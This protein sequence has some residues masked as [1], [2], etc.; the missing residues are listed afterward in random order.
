MQTLNSSR[1]TLRALL[2]AA[3]VTA[4]L[5]APSTSHAQT[6]LF[7]YEQDVAA[8]DY[9]AP[10][11]S[12]GGSL[13]DDGV[14]A[15]VLPWSFPWYGASY[16]TLY[17]GDNG[18]ISF[19]STI[20]SSF[21][22]GCLPATFNTVD[23]AAFWDDLEAGA[24]Q[25]DVH[26]WHDQVGGANRVIVSW[27]DLPAWGAL[28]PNGVTFQAHLYPT[29]AVELHWLDTDFG[30]AFMDDGI[31]ATIGIQDSAGGTYDPIEVSCLTASTLE[32]TALSFSTCDDVD[33]D[34][35]TDALCGGDDCD[36]ADATINPGAT[37]V[38]DNAI[39]EDCSTVADV[40]DGDSDS[41]T[42]VACGGDDCD[43]ANA[44]IN[45]SVDADGD[46]SNACL[47]CNDTPGIGAFLFPGNTEICGDSVDQD[48]SGS[49]DLPDVDGDTYISVPCGGDDCDD[50]DAAVNIGADADGDGSDACSDCDDAD[51]TAFPGNPEVCDSGVDNDCDGVAD[52][53]DN[54]GDGDLAIP[55]GGTDCDDNDPAVGAGTDADG[56]GV[57][58]CNDCDDN[59]NT[60]YP[61]AP[62]TCDGVDSDCDGLLDGQDLDVGA[63][64]TLDEGLEANDGGF[65]ASAPTGSTSL[66]EYGVP[67]AGPTAAF[68]GTKVWGTVLAGNYGVDNNTSHLSLGSIALP[69]GTPTL[70]FAYWQDNESSCSY[71]F[72]NLEVDDGTGFVVAPD[73]DPCSGGFAD[74][75]GYWESMSIDLSTWSGQTVELRFAHTTDT[76]NAD[77][78]GF[79]VD[80]LEILVVDDADGDGWVTCGDC[81]DTDVNINPD[82]LETCDDGIDQ[83]CDGVD[84][85]G[86][87]DGD[88][89]N[90]CLDCDD[91]DPNNFP[92]NLEICADGID[93]DCSGADDTGDADG[94]T[95]ISDVCI[96]GDDCDD[97]NAAVFPGA[98]DQDGDGFDICDDCFDIGGDTEALV[99]PD[100]IEVCDGLDNDCDGATDN[101][102]V[103]GDLFTLCDDCD[104][105]DP[106]VNPDGTEICDDGIDQDCTGTDLV[107]DLDNDG[108]I[109]DAC[110]GDDCDDTNAAVNPSADDV[111]DGVDLNCDGETTTTDAD[112]DGHYDAACGG[113]DCDETNQA[114]HPDAVEAC[115]GFDDNCDGDL[116]AEGEADGDGDGAPGCNDCDDEDPATFPG[117]D[118]LCDELDND[119]DGEADNGVIRDGDQDGFERAA[120]GGSDCDDLNAEANPD[121]AED[122]SDGLDNDCDGAVDDAD[123]ECEFTGGCDCESSVSPIGATPLALLLPLLAVG[124]RRRRR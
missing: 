59:D 122:C 58:A 1:T 73:G 71:D 34:G 11:P 77:Y 2:L 82:A 89:V 43:D 90:A 31:S 109:N 46:G 114:V 69:T 35:Y 93:Q 12:T 5:L 78:P 57:D 39:D 38:C 56:D 22:N 6:N 50:F 3:L 85:T 7:G 97:T 30:D 74:T 52:D 36:D 16:G 76:S 25:G 80:D 54:D 41:Y 4:P 84:A 53:V 79:Y 94:D 44:A 83:N 17:A 124:H 32:L 95:Y 110:G 49:D 108:A 103:D 40:S 63:S 111:C 13:A 19:T 29:G 62:E 68:T 45:P 9:V 61:D 42:N 123:T 104:D 118:E 26:V 119:C 14:F 28:V 72:T 98:F 87:A 92:G 48:C 117:A 23:I 96:G 27:E 64:V 21:S 112:G 10:P 81:D 75:L 101:L 55:C 37:E 8:Y 106:D 47:D 51:I 88:G 65:V 120:C 91:N 100:A 18:D 15:F 33:G 66:F 67:T 60:V 105:D 86:D 102:D 121:G 115:N 70:T 107:G 116:L 20:A 99:N 24:G 113:G